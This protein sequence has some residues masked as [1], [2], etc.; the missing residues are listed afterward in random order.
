MTTF[1]ELRN[2][3]KVLSND[4]D[5]VEQILHNIAN[6]GRN[7]LQV[8]SFAVLMNSV[9]VLSTFEHLVKINSPLI[10]EYAGTCKQANNGF[11][12]GCFSF[13]VILCFSVYKQ[14]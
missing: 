4:F 13:A 9:A 2:N 3:Q 11:P 7:Q 6:D 8:N 14:A 5:V 10:S 1:E 12:Y